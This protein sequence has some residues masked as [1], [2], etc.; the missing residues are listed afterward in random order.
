LI[1][2]KTKETLS[3]ET[4]PTQEARRAPA[5]GMV[6]QIKVFFIGNFHHSPPS[7]PRV[8]P[9]NHHTSQTQSSVPA[10]LVKAGASREC[11]KLE[12]KLRGDSLQ[13]PTLVTLDS[14]T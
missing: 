9:A 6:P 11:R 4:K 14:R 12:E 8:K 2:P 1:Q 5:R 7:H 3:K 13:L 10:I